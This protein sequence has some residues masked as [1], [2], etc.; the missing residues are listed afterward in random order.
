MI[1]FANLLHAIAIALDMI[2][3][4]IIFFVVASA[5]ISWVNPDPYNPIVRF[6][7]EMTDP[8]YRPIRKYVPLL[9]GR[10]DISPIVLLIV[11]YF[12]QA[13]LVGTID[14]YSMQLKLEALRPGL[15]G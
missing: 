10:I 11:V 9:G 12:L 5:L 14:G 8:L 7:R 3:N 15:T 4:M 1:L 2:F 6:L 13:F